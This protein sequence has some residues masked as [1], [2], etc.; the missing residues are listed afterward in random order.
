MPQTAQQYELSFLRACR[1]VDISWDGLQFLCISLCQRLLKSN[2][3]PFS[4]HAER[5]IFRSICNDMGIVQVINGGWNAT[6]ILTSRNIWTIWDL[7]NPSRLWAWAQSLGN[8]SGSVSASSP[9]SL[10]VVRIRQMP[11]GPPGATW[12]CLGGAS[13]H[14]SEHAETLI[15]AETVFGLQFLCIGLCRRLFK[16]MSYP[17]S[18]HAERLIL[19]ETVFNF[20]AIAY[21]G[22]CSKVWVI[23]SQSMQMNLY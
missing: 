6:F 16:S 2:S 7:S 18:K 3:Y 5:S 14:F 10:R 23:Q 8:S 13:Y 22:D 9:R 11:L 1:K 4:E 17:F 21:A 15:L 20:Y 19:A 12:A